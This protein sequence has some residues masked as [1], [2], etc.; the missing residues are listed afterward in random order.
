MYKLCFFI[1]LLFFFVV[2][3]VSPLKGYAQTIDPFSN[4][5]ADVPRTTHTWTQTA[6]IE[7]GSS[8]GCLM[9]GIDAIDPQQ[10]CLGIDPKTRKIGYVEEAGGGALGAVSKLISMTFTPPLHTSDYFTHLASNFGIVKPVYAAPNT[11]AGFQGLQPLLP[12]WTAFR[13]IV[14]LIMVI[15]LLVVGVAIM[16]RLNIDPRTVMSIENQ[17]PKIIIGILMIT[18]SF[19]IAGFLVDMMYVSIYLIAGVLNTVPGANTGISLANIQG[20]NALQFANST[21]GAYNLGGFAGIANDPAAAVGDVA[22]ALFAGPLITG[23][24]AVLGGWIGWYTGTLTA[25]WI[26]GGTG[27]GLGTVAGAAAVAVGMGLGSVFANQALNL[28][29]HILV[30]FVFA[31]ALLIALF[32]LWFALIFA[33]I[34]F[35]LDVVF[36]PFWIIG[37]MIPGSPLNLEGWLRDMIANLSVF[38][39]TITMFLIGQIFLASFQGSNGAMFVPPL[40]GNPG[41]IQALSSIIGFAIIMMTPGVVT[42]MRDLLKTPGFKYSA[43]AFKSIG[44][45]KGVLSGGVGTGMGAMSAYQHGTLPVKEGMGGLK[46]YLTGKLTGGH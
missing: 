32:R 2:F 29:V 7:I 23:V 41:S 8:L 28:F 40:I 21:V 5:N 11:G 27:L 1:S 38:P 37:G 36:A 35:L 20:Q 45:G 26:A 25:N 43:E 12:L 24:F 6:M 13:N 44:S 10:K 14:Y 17:L 46:H 30:F 34:Y 19:A 42:M 39:V 22:T 33:Y 18:F 15:I 3:L 16:L 31:A 9:V 4:V